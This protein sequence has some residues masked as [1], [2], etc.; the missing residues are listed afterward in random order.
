M[1]REKHFDL[2]KIRISV[3]MRNGSALD[4]SILLLA[5]FFFLVYIPLELRSLSYLIYETRRASYVSPLSGLICKHEIRKEKEKKTKSK[6]TRRKLLFRREEF[7][8][9][10][11]FRR[12]NSISLS[13]VSAHLI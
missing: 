3:L 7:V 10:H 8:N 12:C 1:K 2:Y 13:M 11:S 5:F 9:C 6:T 4:S